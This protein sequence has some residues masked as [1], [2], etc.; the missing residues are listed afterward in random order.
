MPESRFWIDSSMAT[1]VRVDPAYPSSF[2]A[3]WEVGRQ[4]Q[5]RERQRDRGGGAERP[6]V[7]RL[8]TPEVHARPKQGGEEGGGQDG[9]REVSEPRVPGRGHRH[10]QT[11]KPTQ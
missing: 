4:S 5:G 3:G 6:G 11:A 7:E 8:P 1:A 9:V 10:V 2:G